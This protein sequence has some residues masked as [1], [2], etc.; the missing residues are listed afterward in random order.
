MKRKKH[1]VCTKY[2]VILLAKM[3]ID[4]MKKRWYHVT[5]LREG[6]RKTGAENSSRNLENDRLAGEKYLKITYKVHQ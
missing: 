2:K 1:A 5:T 4:L 6:T 3:R